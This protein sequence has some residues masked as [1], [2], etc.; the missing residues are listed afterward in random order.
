LLTFCRELLKRLVAISESL[1]EGEGQLARANYKLAVLYLEKGM[2]AESERFKARAIE[3]RNRLR[4][5][6]RD[7]PFEEEEYM[8]LC[9][10]MLW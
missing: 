8:K 7:V 9:L 3:V 5:E 4:Q 1:N 6:P 2:E 10:W